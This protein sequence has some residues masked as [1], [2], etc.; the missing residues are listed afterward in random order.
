MTQQTIER[1]M[2]LGL[3][4]QTDLV[5]GKEPTLRFCELQAVAETAEQIGFDSLWI[6]DHLIIR[7]PNEE[8][9]GCWEA[10]TFLSALAAVTR[11]MQLGSLVA[12]ASFRSP[13]LLAKMADSLDEI[14]AGRFILGL[15]AGW[16]EPEYTAFGYPFEHLT[17]RFEEALQIITPLLREGRVDFTGL[18][19][20]ARRTA[21]RLRGPSPAGPPIWIGAR[22]PRMLE[23][24]ARCANAWNLASWSFSP[25][26]VTREY[27]RLVEVCERIGRDPAT[28]D[29]TANVMVQVRSPGQQVTAD[30]DVLVGSPEEIAAAL[31]AFAA[32]GVRHLVISISPG[33]VAGVERFGRVIELLDQDD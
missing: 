24:T 5:P 28:L 27:S 25:E 23:L 15:G 4:P 12:C 32:V 26:R 29:L 8:E 30:A 17:N 16:H 18:Y 10:F 14:S 3:F 2:K 22:G 7:Y 9:Q 1:R 20:Q 33:G 21:R 31:R 13:A 19:Y 6:A 11:R